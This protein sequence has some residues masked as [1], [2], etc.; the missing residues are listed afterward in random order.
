MPRM[1]P[2]GHGVMDALRL[3]DG[4]ERR[5]SISGTTVCVVASS[6]TLE[7]RMVNPEGSISVDVV[8]GRRNAKRDK[9]GL[10]VENYWLIKNPVS[11]P[12]YCCIG[13]LSKSP[14]TLEDLQEMLNAPEIVC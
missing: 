13:P 4:E 12:G 10:T 3:A 14:T 9:T 8:G 5:L 2:F 7:Q 6:A 1:M 11:S